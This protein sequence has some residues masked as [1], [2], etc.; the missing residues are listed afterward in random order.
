MI[1]NYMKK[2]RT[3]TAVILLVLVYNVNAQNTPGTAGTMNYH[4]FSSDKPVITKELESLTSAEFKSHPE[5]GKLPYNAP[6]KDC[7]ELLQK[8]D[9][10][11]RYFVMAGT[12]G[13]Q[14]DQQTAYGDINYYQNGNLVAIDAR[15]KPS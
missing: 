9:E 6:C 8:R 4:S 11:H 5:Y 2:V 7:F 1:K 15:I 10:T 13:R 14:V 3:I 12:N